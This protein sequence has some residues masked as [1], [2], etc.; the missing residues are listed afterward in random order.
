MLFL[1]RQVGK[2]VLLPIS[3]AHYNIWPQ[4]P[5]ESFLIVI[6]GCKLIKIVFF[7]LYISFKLSLVVSNYNILELLGP[8][9]PCSRIRRPSICFTCPQPHP[10]CPLVLESGMSVIPTPHPTVFSATKRTHREK[11][12]PLLLSP[13]TPTMCSVPKRKT[14]K[15]FDRHG[16]ILR[17]LQRFGNNLRDGAAAAGAMT[18]LF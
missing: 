9:S 16:K 12:K 15:G 10:W 2:L 7:I 3:V 14:G 18:L 8:L 6:W 1:S 17:G 5:T 13:Q 4:Y 11:L